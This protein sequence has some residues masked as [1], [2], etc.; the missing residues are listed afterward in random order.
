MCYLIGHAIEQALTRRGFIAGSAVGASLIAPMMCSAVA[1][2]GSIDTRIQVA[3]LSGDAGNSWTKLILL[4]TSGG[5]TWWLNSDQCGISS[6]VAVGDAYYIVDCGE[7]VGKRLR[8][9]IPPASTT[10]MNASM[11][12][13]FLT[14]LHS[15]HTVGYANLLLFG[16]FT[17][18][19]RR[20]SP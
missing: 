14:H 16:L 10:V 9:A 1:G 5:P 4:G 12:A 3:Q 18:L 6:V 17:G 20:A 7:G 11:R 13:I 2:D 19:D 8:Q 15:D